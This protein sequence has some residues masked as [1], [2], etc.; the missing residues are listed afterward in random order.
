MEI[1]NQ[2]GKV[3]YEVEGDSLIGANLT[4]ANLTGAYY[5]LI[6]VL[7]A[8][9]YDCS[10][11]LTLE[12]MRFDCEALPGGRRLFAQWKKTGEC[13][14]GDHYIRPLW[15]REKR[16]LWKWDRAKPM[17]ELWEMICKEKNIRC[18]EPELKAG[19][20]VL[21]KDGDV[22]C[23]KAVCENNVEAYYSA[24]L[25]SSTYSKNISDLTRTTIEPGDC[26][27]MKRDYI[28]P[29]AD[30]LGVVK[31]FNDHGNLEIVFPKITV[32]EKPEYCIL[33]AK[34]GK[35]GGA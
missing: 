10:D 9:W 22:M 11:A 34:G 17:V 27:R 20:W 32:W 12:L 16:D 24:F 5:S 6:T 18:R 19:D 4:R 1:K 14:F 2:N 8:Q 25:V 26:V 28:T 30:C 21:D 23:V 31:S 15:F 3:I 29:Q 35:G 7:Q 33:I 13:P